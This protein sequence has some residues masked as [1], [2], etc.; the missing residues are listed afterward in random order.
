MLIIEQ[1]MSISGVLITSLE[2]LTSLQEGGGRERERERE[3]EGGGERGLAG[4]IHTSLV[5]TLCTN[6]H[7]TQLSPFHTT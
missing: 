3:K 6:L 1:L 5:Y 4:C 2:D 7:I